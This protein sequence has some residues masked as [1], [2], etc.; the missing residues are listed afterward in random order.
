MRIEKKNPKNF[1]LITKDNSIWISISAPLIDGK[2]PFQRKPCGSEWFCCWSAGAASFTQTCQVWWIINVLWITA[3][4]STA[5]I[6]WTGP[7]RTKSVWVMSEMTQSD[8]PVQRTCQAAGSVLQ[9][10]HLIIQFEAMVTN[11]L[12]IYEGEK[13]H[14]IFSQGQRLM[15]H[16][17]FSRRERR[18]WMRERGR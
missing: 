15:L 5:V 12:F 13:T 10:E 4:E 7:E 14:T 11:Y 2:D 3:V 1:C 9:P 8:H 18:R 16:F 17:S 6:S